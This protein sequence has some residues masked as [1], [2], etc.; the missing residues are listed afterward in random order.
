M[1]LEIVEMGTLKF[2]SCVAS[3]MFELELKIIK[4]SKNVQNDGIFAR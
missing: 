2:V 3:K 1:A 4:L